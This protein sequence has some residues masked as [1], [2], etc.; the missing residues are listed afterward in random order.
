MNHADEDYQVNPHN[1][2]AQLIIEKIEYPSV[3]DVDMLEDTGR[4]AAGFGSTGR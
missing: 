1:R 2:I 3:V 4:S